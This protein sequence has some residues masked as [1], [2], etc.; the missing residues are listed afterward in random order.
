MEVPHK[1]QFAWL[2]QGVSTAQSPQ[3]NEAA[4]LSGELSSEDIAELMTIGQGGQWWL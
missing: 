3:R 2:F 1:Q 4:S